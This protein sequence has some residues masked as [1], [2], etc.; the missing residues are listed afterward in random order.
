MFS[1]CLGSICPCPMHTL[2]SGTCWRIMLAMSSRLLTRLL[3]TNTCP[4]RLISKLMASVKISGENV[5]SSVWMGYRLG[6][7]VCITDRSLAPMS[8]NCSVRGMGVAVSVRVS[9]LVRICLSFSLTETPNFCS[10]SMMSSPRSLNFTLLPT[11][12]CVPM[13]MSVLPSS[14]S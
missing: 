13:M 1:S 5:C 12:L 14:R 4:F 6:G 10:S 11:S 9:T 7:G 8:E 3:T 2:A